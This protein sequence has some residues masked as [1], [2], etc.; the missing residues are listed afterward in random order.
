MNNKVLGVA[1]IATLSAGLAFSTH[2]SETVSKTEAKTLVNEN[3]K[4]RL[5]YDID[6]N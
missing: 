5:V 2:A 6:S 3:N 4:F 1:I